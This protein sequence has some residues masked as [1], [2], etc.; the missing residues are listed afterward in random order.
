MQ[1]SVSSPD[2]LAAAESQLDW[3]LY[4]GSR[5][6]THPREFESQVL[7]RIRSLCSGQALLVWRHD[8]ADGLRIV[9]QLHLD[10]FDFLRSGPA[11]D[12]H[13]RLL[14][15]AS[16]AKPSK[17][18]LEGSPTV[19]GSPGEHSPLE[20][21]IASAPLAGAVRILV[22]VIRTP[23]DRAEDIDS[24]VEF[25]EDAELEDLARS[26]EFVA[27]YLRVLELREAVDIERERGQW[28]A[29]GRQFQMQLAERNV[30]QAIVDLGRR[31]VGCDRVVVAV[32]HG[33]KLR[34]E[35]VTGQE[36]ISH[37]ANLVRLMAKVAQ[38]V[39]EQ[40]AAAAYEAPLAAPDQP[41]SDRAIPDP[42]P[43]APQL[44]EIVRKYMEEAGVISLVLIPLRHG[45]AQYLEKR[46]QDQKGRVGVL[47]CEQ[48]E[49]RASLPLLKRRADLLAGC[50]GPALACAQ[51]YQFARL[52]TLGRALSML[53]AP[54]V[55][56]RFI[57]RTL[58]VSAL[59][60]AAC[61]PLELKL[62]GQGKLR[63]ESRAGIFAPEQG[64]VTQVLVAQGERVKQGQPVAV[65]ESVDLAIRLRQS[66]TQHA[67]S[68]DRL[69]SKEAERANRNIS[70][71]R[72]IELDGEIVE[73]EAT[74]ATSLQQSDILERRLES[75]TLRAPMDGVIT[76]WQPSVTLQHRPVERGS[77]LLHEV[78]PEGPWI[79]EIGVPEDRIAYINEARSQLQSGDRLAVEYMLSTF[80]EQ[81]FHGWLSK[82]SPRSE[83]LE[84][85]HLVYL[86]IELDPQNLPP[87]REGAE[88]KA[89]I[90]CGP[91]YAGF[92]ALREIIDFVRTRI[93]F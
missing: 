86:T 80:P 59:V 8:G 21:L 26:T 32:R 42:I 46:C 87:L 43:E 62:R 13:R 76:T 82:V 58:I 55:W 7:D 67:Q 37:R 66:R 12:E 91:H 54:G 52:S 56:R 93:L 2:R 61:L 38:H 23:S 73:L 50:C 92:V 6:G 14:K 17:H 20:L 40:N 16:Q 18:L 15:S 36:S 77:L 9:H 34:I 88:V 79:I 57:A 69:R 27:D 60:A 25:I 33:S 1:S 35:A 29:L 68:K 63:A 53:R 11:G 10:R 31:Q 83:I 64:T 51:Q 19:E 71:I 85:A 28:E 41:G 5:L 49:R 22:E 70:E 74:V 39:W 72:R 24:R 48:L 4:Q 30:A 45:P 89:K 81:T 84:G 75:L 65:M 78:K 44:P 90:C 3:A 47:F